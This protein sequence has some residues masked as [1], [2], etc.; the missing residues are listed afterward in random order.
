MDHLECMVLRLHS[1]MYTYNP[2]LDAIKKELFY[3]YEIASFFMSKFTVKYGFNPTEDEIGF[4]TFHIGTSIERMK[5]KQ[6]QKFTATLVCMTGFGTSQFL[7][8]KLAG[9]FSNLEIREVFSAS[10]LS[11]IKPEKQDF[12]IATVPIELE[13][14]PVIQ[15]SPVLSETDI[16]KI[17][18]FLMKKK[19]YEPETQK[20]YEYLQQFLHSE[21]AMF[22]CDLKSKEEVIHLLGSRMITEGYVDEGFIDSVFERENLSETALGNLIAIPHAFEGHI[23]KQGIGIMTLKKPINWGDEKVQLIFLLSLDVNSKDY[24]KGIFGDVLELTKDKKAMEVILKAR[25]FSE[26]FR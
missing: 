9:S 16:K 20:N 5:Q 8:V 17:Q 23:K 12:V 1:K 11:E 24:I 15:V 18:K 26:M 25:K 14:I 13:G 10:R 4:I 2:I 6:H 22:D 7:R 21:I 3:E 19:E